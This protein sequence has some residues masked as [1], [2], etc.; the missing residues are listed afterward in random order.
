MPEEPT[1]ADRQSF[2]E[3]ERRLG[4]LERE[5]RWWRGGLIAALVLIVLMLLTGGHRHRHIDVMLNAPPWACRGPYWGWGPVPYAIPQRG[6]PGGV[7]GS[8]PNAPAQQ[9]PPG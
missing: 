4:Q 7:P 3:L 8:G 5:N 2:M 9:P 6:Q 1:S